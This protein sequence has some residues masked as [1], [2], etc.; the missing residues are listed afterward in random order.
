MPVNK[1]GAVYFLHKLFLNKRKK[2]V[3]GAT[4]IIEEIHPREEERIFETC[5][6]HF[7]KNWKL[8]R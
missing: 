3:Q 2:I 1:V 8:L 4:L 6:K 7:C 5:I